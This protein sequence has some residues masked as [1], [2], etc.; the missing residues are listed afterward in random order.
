MTG[1]FFEYLASGRPILALG[2]TDGDVADIL[3]ET[4]AGKIVDFEDEAG[5][6]ATVLDFYNH[7]KNGKLVSNPADCQ[8]YSR[9]T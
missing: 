7:Y 3:Q 8:K 9:K 6:K 5:M 1:K 2:A 4:G